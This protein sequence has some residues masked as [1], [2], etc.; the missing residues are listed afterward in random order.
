MIFVRRRPCRR[1]LISASPGRMHFAP[2][3]E[4]VPLQHHVALG[5]M[6]IAC[7]AA[8][9]ALFVM[10]L[11]AVELRRCVLACSPLPLTSQH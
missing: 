2:P 11:E 8:T 7:E 5:C 4:D 1:L 10:V 3:S 9:P 6:E